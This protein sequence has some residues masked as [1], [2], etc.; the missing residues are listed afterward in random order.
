M[1]LMKARLLAGA[2]MASCSAVQDLTVACTEPLDMLKRFLRLQMFQQKRIQTTY[3]L[4]SR[5]VG[6]GRFVLV[7]SSV[8]ARRLNPGRCL[9]SSKNGTRGDRLFFF[10]NHPASF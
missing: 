10:A 5:F 1:S 9:K 7:R 3:D 8:C 6:C 4:Q 2:A